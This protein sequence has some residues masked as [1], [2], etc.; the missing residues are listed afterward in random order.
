MKRALLLKKLDLAGVVFVR[1]G[2]GHDLY[3]QPKTGKQ[4][5][6]PRHADINERLAKDIIKR[7]S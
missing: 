3:R 1:H 5:S 6:V 4:E 7:L 2:A